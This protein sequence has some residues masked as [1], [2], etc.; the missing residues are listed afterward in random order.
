M[1]HI[2]ISAENNELNQLVDRANRDQEPLMIESDQQS[3]VLLSQDEWRGI[4]ETIYLVSIPGMRDSIR[5]G[6]RTPI[7]DCSEDIDW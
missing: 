6:L 7:D 1:T 5:E 3:A 4:Q 2:K